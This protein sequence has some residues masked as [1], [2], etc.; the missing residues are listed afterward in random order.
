MLFNFLNNLT[1]LITAHFN[2]CLFRYAFIS[3]LNTEETTA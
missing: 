2:H 3:S 1:E